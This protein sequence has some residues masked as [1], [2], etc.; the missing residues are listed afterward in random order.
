MHEVAPEK[1]ILEQDQ[2]RHAARARQRLR[3]RCCS[4]QAERTQHS[5]HSRS[6]RAAE[7]Q[8]RQQLRGSGAHAE[9]V[10]G[11]LSRSASAAGSHRCLSA[12]GGRAALQGVQREAPR[13]TEKAESLVCTRDR[14]G[15]TAGG[16]QNSGRRT[17]HIIIHNSQS[18]RYVLCTLVATRPAFPSRAAPSVST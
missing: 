12:S 7:Q 2:R 16:S 17:S 11:Q 8:Q 3:L 18:S 4:Q 10:L 1:L 9:L 5:Q 14:P 13:P 6:R 15:P